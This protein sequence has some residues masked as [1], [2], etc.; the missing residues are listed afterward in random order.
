MAFHDVRF[1]LCIEIGATGGPRF[2]TTVL[3][4]GSGYEKRNIEWSRVRG[5]WDVGSGVK[6][7][8]DMDAVI[9]FFYARQGRAHAFRFRDWTDYQIGT[10]G[11]P[12]TIGTGTGALTQFQLTKRYT[13][14]SYYFD[15]KITR[16][17]SGTVFVR[18]NESPTR[19][20]SLNTS[21]GLVTFT[22]PPGNGATVTAWGEF[23]VPARF[24]TDDLNITGVYDGVLDIPSIPIV[25][26]RE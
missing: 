12:L 10:V 20:Y 14:G 16:P 3:G 17:V 19:S 6:T 26:V 23:D 25:E 15:R 11:V 9:A 7:K 5:A 13:S 8:A 22:T 2:R 21:T 24:D 18:T 1:P 4:L